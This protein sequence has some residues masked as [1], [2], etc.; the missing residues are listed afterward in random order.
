MVVQLP[1]AAGEAFINFWSV[2]LY[3]R[4]T[5]I[6][7]V[8]E[9][10]IRDSVRDG[11]VF[12]ML[13]IAVEGKRIQR[14][15]GPGAVQGSLR[16]MLDTILRDW[17]SAQQ[18]KWISKCVWKRDQ[19]GVARTGSGDFHNGRDELRNFELVYVE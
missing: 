5:V 3:A 15:Q 11:V 4:A 12:F 6:Q 8:I 17:I 13:S 10:L 2:R 14:L 18:P 9:P 1:C 19:G 16:A 7:L